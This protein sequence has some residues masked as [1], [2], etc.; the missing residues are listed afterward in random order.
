MV[1]HFVTCTVWRVVVCH[2]QTGGQEGEE[3]PLQQKQC[4]CITGGDDGSELY[5]VARRRF[6]SDPEQ[7]QKH[8]FGLLAAER[9][10]RAEGLAMGQGGAS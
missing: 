8:E 10:F 3:Q 9:L 5:D 6:F 2:K 7:A 4:Y 1:G